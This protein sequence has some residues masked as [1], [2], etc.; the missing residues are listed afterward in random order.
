VGGFG[1]RRP[2]RPPGVG[3]GAGGRGGRSG[4]VSLHTRT[5]T[6]GRAAEAAAG[7]R[8]GCVDDG[9]QSWLESTGGLL[10]LLS[11]AA[12]EPRPLACPRAAD[13]WGL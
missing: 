5:A 6:R 12:V 13:G 10:V 9:R 1:D 4:Q 2:A 7:E 11:S 3:R 8:D